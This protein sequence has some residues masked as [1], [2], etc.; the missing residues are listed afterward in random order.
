ME[1]EERD[2]RSVFEGGESWME[3]DQGREWKVAGE[4]KGCHAGP[5]RC[6]AWAQQQHWRAP[7]GLET[8]LVVAEERDFS[9]KRGHFYS[10]H[11]EL[12][13]LT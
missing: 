9:Y 10:G 13:Q 5:A 7:A 3:L 4:G 8:L 6:H 11:Y 12:M 1:K 2:A